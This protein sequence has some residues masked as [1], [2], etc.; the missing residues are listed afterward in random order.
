MVEQEGWENVL[1][2]IGGNYGD[3][4]RLQEQDPEGYE[5]FKESQMKARMNVDRDRPASRGNV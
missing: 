3:L 1:A 5:Q 4:R 2:K